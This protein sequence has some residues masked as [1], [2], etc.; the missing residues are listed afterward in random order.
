MHAPALM[1]CPSHAMPVA[2]NGNI[3][4]RT[5]CNEN[6]VTDNFAIVIS[7]LSDNLDNLT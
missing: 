3:K 6:K 5:Y 1:W 7:V 2:V 4:Y